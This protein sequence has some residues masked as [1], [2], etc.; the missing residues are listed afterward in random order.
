MEAISRM[1]HTNSSPARIAAFDFGSNSFHIAVATVH[2]GRVDMLLRHGER[3][4]LAAGIKGRRLDASSIARALDSVRRF[5]ELVRPLEPQLTRAVAT[6]AVRIVD[7]ADDFLLPAR[8]LLEL[9]IDVISGSEEAS[10]IYRGVSAE[11][12]QPGTR[13]VVIDIGGGSTELVLGQG[14]DIDLYDSLDLG[15]LT[16]KE[17]FFNNPEF[18]PASFAQA[19]E[20]AMAMLAPLASR[21]APFQGLHVGTSGTLQAIAGILHQHFSQPAGVIGQQALLAMPRELVTRHGHP[22]SFVLKGLSEERRPVFASGLAIVTALFLQLGIRSLQIAQSDLRDGLLL[23]LA[24]TCTQAH[25]TGLGQPVP[26]AAL[27]T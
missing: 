27:Y 23:G 20:Y 1:S 12:A 24:E 7:N 15:C 6:H 21:Y 4:Q 26:P 19:V 16:L 2:D 25:N 5:T 13:R 18:D 10:L 22:G 17:R 9:P 3:V 11:L 14:D 8:E